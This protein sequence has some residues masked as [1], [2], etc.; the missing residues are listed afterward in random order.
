LGP[1]ICY[2]KG[3]FT[4]SVL[5]PELQLPPIC[6]LQRSPVRDMKWMQT[7]KGKIPMVAGNNEQLIF[8]DST[9]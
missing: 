4:V 6:Y 1:V 8:P 3:N 7:Q 9:K 2:E 5:P